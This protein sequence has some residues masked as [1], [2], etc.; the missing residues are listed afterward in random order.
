MFEDLDTG[1]L[2]RVAEAGYGT[3]GASM[4]DDLGPDSIEAAKHV[5]STILHGGN[6]G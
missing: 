5:R 1:V 3:H 4:P 2:L 6:K